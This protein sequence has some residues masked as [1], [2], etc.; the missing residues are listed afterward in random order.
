[1]LYQNRTSAGK[2]LAEFLKKNY[3]QQ[4]KSAVLISIL[5]GG[6]PLGK[7][8]EKKL[9]IPHLPIPCVSIKENQQT[10]QSLGAYCFDYIYKPKYI[11]EQ[12]L[13][14][15][16]PY[17][18]E[19]FELICQQTNTNQDL[20]SICSGKTLLVVDDFIQYGYTVSAVCNF[21][22]SFKPQK[23]FIA[24]PICSADCI[25]FEFSAEE[26]FLNIEPDFYTPSQYYFDFDEI[27]LSLL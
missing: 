19:E 26:I 7:E 13:N 15:Y 9:K 17:Y 22:N 24:V 12:T 18:Q 4:L 3:Y 21:L 2:H 16:L 8:I 10:D 25:E 27:D 23:I 5:K 11:S 6:L 1:M 14:K 20:Y